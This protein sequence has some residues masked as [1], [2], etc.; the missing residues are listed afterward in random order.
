MTNVVLCR[1][2]WSTIR[3]DYSTKLPDS[4]DL[5]L[6]YKVTL[7]ANAIMLFFFFFWH[8]ANIRQLPAD[9]LSWFAWRCARCSHGLH[10][11]HY[12]KAVLMQ[13]LLY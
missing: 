4:T 13:P 10:I 6:L 9:K 11:Q 8:A 2:L 3:A 7:S 1:E 5:T 12:M